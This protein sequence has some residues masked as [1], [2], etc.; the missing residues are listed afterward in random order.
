MAYKMHDFVER[1]FKIDDAVGAV[2]VHG[3]CGLFGG[4]VAGFALWGYPAIYPSAGALITLS[5]GA[6][7]FGTNAEGLPIVTPMG[8]T[9]VSLVFAIG[10]GLIPG[11]VL[12]ML[13]QELRPPARASDGRGQGS[14]RRLRLTTPPSRALR[15]RS[16]PSAQRSQ[17]LI[18]QP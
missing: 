4:I 16:K 1:K 11:Y 9:I 8:N 17:D 3:Y 7:W 2:A 10:F 6:G 18:A 13:P 5:E 12:G 15:R 14:R